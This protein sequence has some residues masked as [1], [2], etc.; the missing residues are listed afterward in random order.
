M[1]SETL[2]VLTQLV[3]CHFIQYVFLSKSN[4]LDRNS[5]GMIAA[6]RK[7]TRIYFTCSLTLM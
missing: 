7:V 2:T 4:R 1:L 6:G 3:L 5:F